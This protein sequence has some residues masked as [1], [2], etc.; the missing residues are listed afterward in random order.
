MTATFSEAL[1]PATINASTFELRD[2]GNNLVSRAVTYNGTTA[3]LTPTNPLAASTTYNAKVIGGSN[4]VKDL[5]GNALATDYGWSFSTGVDPCSTAGNPIVCENSRT[6]NPSSEW[7]ISGAGDPSI[8]G[9]ATDISVN[10]GET[11][12]F[13]IDT[14]STD[15]R[16]D[17]Y[18][19]GYYQGTGARKVATV[20]PSAALPQSQPAC[21]TDT[22]GLIDC[23]NWAESASWTVPSDAT[24]G[25]YF[26]KAVREDGR[27]LA[28]RATS[29]SLSAM[30]PVPP[31]FCSRRPTRL[32][33]PIT[34]M[35]ETAFIR[36]PV[37]YRRCGDGRAY[38]VSYNRPFIRGASMPETGYLT[39]NIRWC[40]G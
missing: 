3:T 2:S 6:G 17:I 18:R 28:W 1:D 21:L 8:Q 36:A 5:A 29:S 26:A 24:S 7:D 22:S 31:T 4:G 15:Y 38:K 23:G 10:R 32:G 20:Q 14:P 9:F 35:V 12:R 16:L 25:I 13:K 39:R 11:V 40:A 37:R 34:P 27:V 19:M 30:T 33:M